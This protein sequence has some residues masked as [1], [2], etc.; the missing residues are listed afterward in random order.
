MQIHCIGISCLL[1][2]KCNIYKASKKNTNQ[3]FLHSFENIRGKWSFLTHFNN[4]RLKINL[5]FINYFYIFYLN[6]YQGLCILL[7]QTGDP[8][9]INNQIDAEVYTGLD[10]NL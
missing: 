3:F 6:K 10:K 9:E 2:I 8:D 5:H 4:F 1:L 7:P